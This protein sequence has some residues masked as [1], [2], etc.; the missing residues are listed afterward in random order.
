MNVLQS[1]YKVIVP[2]HK[3]GWVFIA[4]SA[5][6]SVILGLLWS[7]LFWIGLI[8]YRMDLLLFS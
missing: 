5:A 4:I 8:F 6:I 7:P 2:I 1:A 3:E